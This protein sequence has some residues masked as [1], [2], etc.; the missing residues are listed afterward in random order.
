MQAFPIHTNIVLIGQT[1]VYI[2]TAAPSMH[3]LGSKDDHVPFHH[4]RFQL[5]AAP[6]CLRP[7]ELACLQCHLVPLLHC[8]RELAGQAPACQQMAGGLVHIA[9]QL[10]GRALCIRCDSSGKSL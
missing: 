2:T 7:L 5:P 10:A 4:Q 6:Y 8:T 3:P 9:E 1:C